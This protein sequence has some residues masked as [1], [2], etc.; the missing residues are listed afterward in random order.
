MLKN[1]QLHYAVQESFLDF[2]YSKLRPT[3]N[4]KI[5]NLRTISTLDQ[6]PYFNV[7][8]DYLCY[9]LE[10]IFNRRSEDSLRYSDPQIFEYTEYGYGSLD[11][12][13]TKFLIGIDKNRKI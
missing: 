6:Q 7:Y 11:K 8:P 3:K 13:K 9:Y 10:R 1:I 5:K 2:F 12:V 4:K